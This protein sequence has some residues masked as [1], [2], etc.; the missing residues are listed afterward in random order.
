MSKDLRILIRAELNKRTSKNVIENQLKAIKNKLPALNIKLNIDDSQLKKLDGLKSLIEKM[1]KDLNN[2]TN[3]KFS[4][5]I[6]KS[7]EQQIRQTKELNE[8]EKQYQETIKKRRRLSNTIIPTQIDDYSDKQSSGYKNIQDR[9]NEIK[10]SAKDV[11]SITSNISKD[12]G[13]LEKAQ[14]SYIDNLGRKVT[15]YYRLV[16]KL[17]EHGG[18][19]AIDDGSEVP[20][21]QKEWVKEKNDKIVDNIKQQNDQIAKENKRLQKLAQE[22]AKIRR[23]LQG[24]QT[25]GQISDT[26]FEDLSKRLTQVSNEQDL[27]R[28]KE[29]MSNL[30]NETK[31]AQASQAKLN[32][33]QG[34]FKLLLNDLHKEGK[35]TEEQLKKFGKAIDTS[36][37]VGQIK[38]LREEINKLSKQATTK[39][40]VLLSPEDLGLETRKFDNK[41]KDVIRQYPSIDRKSIDELQRS[42]HNLAN[43]TGLTRNQIRDF[44]MSLTE[45]VTNTKQVTANTNTLVGAFQNAMIKFPIW[46]TASTAFFGTA[47]ALRD[48]TSQIIE[49]DKQMTVLKRVSGG[50]ILPNDILKESI[51]LADRLGNTITQLNEGFANFVR[52]GYRGDGLIAMTEA[53]TLFS[54]I[55]E[56]SVEEAADG[57]TSIVNGFSDIA[58]VDVMKAVDAINEVD[59]NFAIT[60][61]NIVASMQRSVGAAETFGVSLEQL[62]GMTVAIGETTRE[63]GSIIGNSLK[64]IFSRITTMDKSVEMLNELNVA[65][66]DMAG[67]VRPVADILTDLA[68]KWSSLS[69]EQ[70]QYIGLQIAGRFQLSRFLVL[71]QNY[72]TAIEATN[73]ALNSAGSGYRENE[74]YL[75]SLEARINILKN[76]WTEFAITVGDALLSDGIVA[77]SEGMA[78]LIKSSSSLVSVLGFLPPVITAVSVAIASMNNGMRVDIIEKAKKNIGAQGLAGA[79]A[80][81]ASSATLAGVALRTFASIIK[82]IP[83]MLGFAAIGFVFE[84]TLSYIMKNREEAREFQKEL[85]EMQQK[86]SANSSEIKQL[87]DDYIKLSE[88]TNRTVEENQQLI[89]T[90]NRLNELYP[91]LTSYID[92]NGNAHLRNAD[93]IK[94]ELE[95]LEKMRELELREDAES[96]ESDTDKLMKEYRKLQKELRNI[97]MIRESDTSAMVGLTPEERQRREIYYLKEREKILYQL[98][99]K[100]LEIQQTSLDNVK[101]RLELN[102]V[103]QKLNDNEQKLIDQFVES[104]KHLLDFDEIADKNTDS[105]FNLSNAIVQYAEDLV[106]LKEKLGEEFDLSI[107]VDADIDLSSITNEQAKALKDVHDEVSKGAKEWDKYEASLIKVGFDKTANFINRMKKEVEELAGIFAD[108]QG[109]FPITSHSQLNQMLEEGI[110]VY[111]EFNGKI[112]EMTEEMLNARNAI[113]DKVSVIERL[114]SAYDETSNEVSVLNKLLEDLA[115]GKQ[116]TATEAMELI[117]KVNELSNA[118]TVENG[119]IKINKKA[120]EELRNTKIKAFGDM[121]NSTKQEVLNTV[122]ATITKLKNYGL[123]IKAIQN[124]ADAKRALAKMEEEYSRQAN[125][126]NG[127]WAHSYLREQPIGQAISQTIDVM[128]YL[129]SIEQLSNLATTSL[130]SVGTSAD[131]A[132]SSTSKAGDSAKHSAYFTDQYKNALEALN[133]QLAKVRNEKDKLIKGSDKWLAKVKQENDLIKQQIELKKQQQASLR[134]QISTGKF[135]QTGMVTTDSP[136]QSTSS[137][138][139]AMLS[140]SQELVASGRFVYKQIGG[141]YKGT[142]DQFVQQAVSDCSQFV[143]EMFKEFL[144]IRLPRTTFEQVKQGQAVARKEDLQVGDLV[145]F[146]TG[147]RDHNHVGIYIG[148]GKFTHMGTK[149]LQTADLNSYIKHSPIS[150]M[151]RITGVNGASY[152]G[153]NNTQAEVAQSTDQAI[154]SIR[155]LESEIISLNEAM[156][157]A[158]EQAQARSEYMNYKR[159]MHD[160]SIQWSQIQMEQLPQ[161]SERY[162]AEL[163][164]QIELQKA[165]QRLM[166][167]EANFWREQLKQME[168]G[169]DEYARA[170]VE[171]SKLKIG[172]WDLD[173]A[174]KDLGEQIRESLSIEKYTRSLDDLTYRL[175]LS[176]NAMELLN[177]ESEEYVDELIKQDKLIRNKIDLTDQEIDRLTKLLPTLKIGSKE[178]EEIANK[179]KELILLVGD[180]NKE[181]LTLQNTTK[182]VAEKKVQAISE[183]ER[184]IID[185]IRKRIEIEK[186]SLQDNLK[187]YEDYMN[188]K[189]RILRK[190]YDEEDWNK[191]L[192]KEQDA[193]LEL[194]G[195]L[196]NQM[197]DDSLA[198]RNRQRALR[199]QIEEQEEKIAEMLRKKGLDKQIEGIEKLIEEE[200]NR[201]KDKIDELDKQLENDKIYAE[202]RKAIEDGHMKWLVRET[203]G[204]YKK[205]GGIVQ[206]TMVDL[207]DA[208]TDFENHYGEGLSILGDKI[209]T[210]FIENIKTAQQEIIRLAELMAEMNIDGF[211]ISGVDRNAP[212]LNTGNETVTSDNLNLLLAKFIND[213]LKTDTT[214][215]KHAPTMEGLE[216]LRSTIV[217]QINDRSKTLDPNNTRNFDSIYYGLSVQEKG[218]VMDY[219]RQRLLTDGLLNS[220]VNRT[221]TNDI[222]NNIARFNTGGYVDGLG[223]N[224][225]LAIVDDKELILNKVDT[226]NILDAVKQVRLLD[227]I[228]PTN[229]TN[230]IKSINP[231]S[232]ISSPTINLNVHGNMDKSVL[233]DVKKM[234]DNGFE[235]YFGYFQKMGIGMSRV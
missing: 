17:N 53:A 174:I 79:Y 5:S 155:Q 160:R 102:E 74:E 54:N 208:Y 15:E 130:S 143:Q 4:S 101:A 189:I 29:S 121:I 39:G 109:N 190:E 204:T 106:S 145:F 46:L 28:Y 73:T 187:D 203:D 105:V 63:S 66:H 175:Q 40:N 185:M 209:K 197:L 171:I 110:P 52:Q 205:I 113:D 72:S 70:Q 33:E 76:S 75:K 233:P 213:K 91:Q 167:E 227:N 230:I 178:Y 24:L 117:K 21:F 210:D 217:T 97:D 108:A 196:N 207:K 192:Q 124:L 88:K 172:W 159:E 68:S 140:K 144:N 26:Q 11:S 183:T 156:I 41:I 27:S 95:Y 151:R 2:L 169:T 77:F 170:E 212:Q 149:G 16:E 58:D 211:D 18:R 146:R 48:I 201:T 235:K 134:N 206:T 141:E 32:Q 164:R 34:K 125:Y 112:V 78:S 6:D 82:S 111:M 120:V 222:I 65:T 228:K 182:Q 69:S 94:L 107:L 13:K 127:Q 37:S 224:G 19:I 25:T 221:I 132:S 8:T 51:D 194:R 216:R 64:T 114:L 30:V 50:E 10:K 218:Q 67:N 157:S 93:A 129:E 154:S 59:N 122:N 229:F 87:A 139:L 56:M 199:L 60:S 165:K 163:E 45:V 7:I 131:K 148:D 176:K 83:H 57:L 133:L 43:T 96:L 195:K 179:I 136:T 20:I 115:N 186:K 180:Y 118:I 9:I 44:N 22:R 147:G 231:I 166:H 135:Q 225:G 123:E 214:M 137:G 219:I 89:E 80:R 142:F 104:N 71:M 62:I 98:E 47:R 184:K 191:Q 14:I 232:N 226:K 150:A 3:I 31:K 177:D 128:G 81:L 119:V 116:I 92:K 198:S 99:R 153:G 100:E 162:R 1:E 23:E 61:Q 38:R 35:I 85:D 202:A 36:D 90:A 126:L 12:T 173:K 42:F 220:D 138:L 49:I 161:G 188:E 215:S 86:Y 181:L 234:I 193:L 84:K 158:F 55:S 152:T 168:K 223:R 103:T 200:R